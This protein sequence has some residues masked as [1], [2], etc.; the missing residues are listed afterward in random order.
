MGEPRV[1]DGEI[2]V[3]RDYWRRY[4]RLPEAGRVFDDLLDARAEITRLRAELAG[5]RRLLDEADPALVDA[6]EFAET[7]GDRGYAKSCLARVRAYLA[8]QP[9]QPEAGD[10]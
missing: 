9:S 8:A 3:L 2:P 6:S 10:G 4:G 1:S 5:A 7:S